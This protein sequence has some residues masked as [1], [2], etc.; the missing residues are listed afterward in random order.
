MDDRLFLY[1]WDI[2]R[3]NKY[4]RRASV[5]VSKASR[6]FFAAAYAGAAVYVVASAPAFTPRNINFF[7]IPLAAMTLS[8]FLR[9]TLKRPRP[10]ARLGVTPLVRTDGAYSLPSNHAASAAVIAAACMTVSLPFGMI[11]AALALLT[12][13]CRVLAGAHFPSDVAAGWALGIAFGLLFLL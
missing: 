9:K 3:K 11:L 8:F 1:L 5:F 6:P 7:A 10:G 12:G 2:S 4:V 13:L